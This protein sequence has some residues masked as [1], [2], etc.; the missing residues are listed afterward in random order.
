[1]KGIEEEE[2]N[3][4]DEAEAFVMSVLKKFTAKGGATVSDVQAVT[5]TLERKT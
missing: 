2:K 1:M 3:Q 4:G 5:P